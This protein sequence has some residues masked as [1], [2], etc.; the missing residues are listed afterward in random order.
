MIFCESDLI[1]CSYG[2]MVTYLQI[3]PIYLTSCM[4]QGMGLLE[5]LLYRQS[6]QHNDTLL[7]VTVS[8]SYYVI[9][10]TCHILR[11]LSIF[12]YTCELLKKTLF[13]ILIQNIEICRLYELDH[14][15]SKIMKV[16]CTCV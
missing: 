11:I 10:F 15:S 12:C 9:C 2:P 3:A 14:I 1:W 6:V 5:N 8:S 13:S 7:K 4:K 16:T